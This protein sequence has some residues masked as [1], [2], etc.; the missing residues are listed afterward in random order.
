MPSSSF[1][2]ADVLWRDCAALKDWA[3]KPPGE[4]WAHPFTPDMAAE[5]DAFFSNITVAV[6]A[7]RKSP[8]F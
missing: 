1:L 5:V 6:G 3:A 2:Y 4:R 8:R 7:M